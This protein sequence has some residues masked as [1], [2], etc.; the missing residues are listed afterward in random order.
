MIVV[1]IFLIKVVLIPLPTPLVSPAAKNRDIFAR[2]EESAARMQRELATT[3][4][5]VDYIDY[6]ATVDTLSAELEEQTRVTSDLYSL[7]NKFEL[8]GNCT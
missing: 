7:I 4:D 1:V 5:L 6:M 8:T 3:L 2:L